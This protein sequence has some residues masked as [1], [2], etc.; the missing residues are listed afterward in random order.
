MD[1]N[2]AETSQTTRRSFVKLAA[3]SAL[4]ASNSAKGAWAQSSADRVAPISDLPSL[5]GELAFDDVARQ[6]AAMD[7][8]FHLRRVPLA[9]LRPRSIDD[10]VRM[11]IYA[12]KRGIKIAMRGQ[13]H[14][15]YGQALVEGGIVIDSSTLKAL[16]LDGSDA[17]D[18]QPGA[19]W[20]DVA[21]VTLGQGLITPVV[22]GSML[23]SF[24][25]TLS[26]GGTGETSYRYGA[27]VDHVLEMDV[28]T[29]AG[30][31]VTCSEEHNSELFRMTL[32][33]LGQ[34]GIIVRARLRLIQAPKFVVMHELTYDDMDSF[35]SDQA[36]LTMIDELGP[37]N[38]RITKNQN[39]SPQFVLLA[40]NGVAEA[41]EVSRQ[42]AWMAGLRFKSDAP[43]KTMPYWEYL[44]RGTAGQTAAKASGKPNPSLVATLPDN[45]VQD[46]LGHLLST[47]EAFIGIWFFEVSPK[48]NARHKQ[49]LQKMPSGLLSFELRMQRRASAT[50]APDHKAMLSMNDTL[51]PKVQ[52]AG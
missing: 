25:G 13:G 17:V 38:G 4:L 48:V 9:V 28:V 16:R 10:I 33:G 20:G 36:R 11:V 47:P 6:S 2:P 49:P 52:A 1:Q 14:S 45:S 40:G 12:N 29:G 5:D 26:V 31:L 3:A 27:Q 37:L 8:G 41:G 7:W 43:A 18:A 22:P 15:E 21:K 50:D 30:E 19:T 34:C 51:L 44:N 42:P 35:F 24:G 32:A 39:G 46:F 23:L